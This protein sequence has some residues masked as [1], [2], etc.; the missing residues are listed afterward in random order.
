[1]WGWAFLVAVVLLAGV[2]GACLWLL[3]QRRLVQA[4]QD[5]LQRDLQQCRQ[6]MEAVKHERAHL[7]EQLRDSFK[8]LAGD[9]LRTSQ[10]DF[11]Q[12]ARQ[13]FQNQQQQALAQLE[14]RKQ[15][16]E[17]L[18]QP[19]RQTL[20]RYNA[21]IQQIESARQEA[22]GSL[23]AQVKAMMEDQRR[24]RDETQKLV[25]A[26]RRPDVR[27]RWGELQLRRIA[28]LAGMVPHCDFDEQVTVRTDDGLYKPDMVVY[29]PAQ[30]LIIIDAKTPMTAYLDAIQCED[31]PQREQCFQRHVGHITQKVKD[32][33]GKRYQDQMG[34]SPDFVVLFIPG[35]SFLYPAVQRSPDL[36]ERAMN[37][38]VVIATPTTLLSLLKAVEVGWREQRLADNARRISELGRELHERVAIVTDYL[39][40]LGTHLGRA[41][42]AYNDL[43]GSFESRVLVSARKFKEL[44][45]DS[46]KELPAEG[47][48][49][50]VE[51][52]PRSPQKRSV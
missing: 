33:A 45:A 26:L 8:A 16:I 1:M 42:G 24:L 6:E 25:S 37:L 22:Y 10:Q 35:E 17:S 27:G 12:L 47:Q 43:V 19:V 9:V 48:I 5:R 31:E 52:L 51:A 21:S 14:Q 50:E 28:E 13:N 44:G 20:E 23:K 38:G 39:D 7:I 2:S 4:Q 30:R 49:K 18:L 36:I 3:A 15:A 32:L 34:R 41:V 11:L 29:L 40:K 46:P